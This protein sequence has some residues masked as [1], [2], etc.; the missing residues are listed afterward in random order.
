MSKENVLAEIQRLYIEEYETMALYEEWNWLQ[1]EF[2]EE[3][4]R[5]AV[6]NIINADFDTYESLIVGLASRRTMERLVDALERY[7]YKMWLDKSF[8]D[9][10]PQYRFLEKYDLS[11]YPKIY[12]TMIT[13]DQI[14][15]KLHEL[16]RLL[17][18]NVT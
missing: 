5:Y 1:Q 16:I 8:Y 9:R 13:L 3:F 15:M 11:G 18:S 14:R 12:K 2:A 7:T 4:R 10:Y 17:D 6:N